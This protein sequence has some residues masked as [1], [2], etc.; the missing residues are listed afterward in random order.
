MASAAE[1]ASNIMA[2]SDT[3]TIH[4]ISPNEILRTPTKP[5]LQTDRI[6]LAVVLSTSLINKTERLRR[7]ISVQIP[8]VIVVAIVGD[9]FAVVLAITLITRTPD[10][11]CGAK[12]QIITRLHVDRVPPDFVSKT[13]R[14]AYAN[15]FAAVLTTTVIVVERS[16]AP[17]GQRTS[18]RHFASL[19][20]A[21]ICSNSDLGNS[22]Q[23]QSGV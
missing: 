23:E 11:R 18:L 5:S 13:T 20:G 10:Q 1:G 21:C 2:F 7:C 4:R 12:N 15:G 14:I 22:R 8:A 6:H 19:R 3:T 17:S 16:I 9:R